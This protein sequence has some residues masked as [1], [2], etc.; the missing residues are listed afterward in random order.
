MSE[1]RMK[2]G[3]VTEYDAGD[4]NK[5]S[6]LG[7]HIANSLS[8][9]GA[10]L[11][12]IGNLTSAGSSLRQI[13]EKIK[14]FNNRGDRW[15][16]INQSE[17]A[18]RKYAATVAKRMA[19]TEVACIFSPS[20]FPVAYLETSTPKVFYT[21]ATFHSMVNF[22][23]GYSGLSAACIDRGDKI[24][25]Q[26]LDTCSL[27]IYSSEWAASSAINYYGVNPGKIR[28]A[29]FGAN[30]LTEQNDKTVSAKKL[31]DTIHFLFIGVDWKRKGGDIVL[32]T[33]LELWRKNIP[34]EL[35]VSGVDLKGKKLPAFVKTYGF[36]DKSKPADQK[37]LKMLFELAD[38]LFVPSVADCSPVVFAEGAAYGVPSVSRAIGGIP[39]IIKDQ[40]NG[41]LM[42]KEAVVEDYVQAIMK[43]LDNPALYEQMRI[44]AFYEYEQKF[45]WS[46]TGKQ[47]MSYLK[48]VVN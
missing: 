21:D 44:N 29:P 4:I 46:S 41:L 48:E 42:K 22:Y 9:A 13:F 23:P 26:A 36:L 25:K 11:S 16:M 15:L 34:V 8:C 37:V 5:W 18:A 3:Y 27:A 43:V 10:E 1:N 17:D 20:S 24:E 14:Y 40:Y 7:Y 38:F 33:C 2:V 31:S 32:D 39:S 19:H 35:H 47:L 6:G 12:F 28:I 45:N 30:L